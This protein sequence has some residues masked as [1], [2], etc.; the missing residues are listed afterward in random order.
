MNQVLETQYLTPFLEL[1]D[2]V[3]GVILPPRSVGFSKRG[4][5]TIQLLIQTSVGN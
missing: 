3:K 4:F 2:I 1:Y 5:T